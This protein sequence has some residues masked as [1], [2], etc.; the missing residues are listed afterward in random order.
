MSLIRHTGVMKSRRLK[1]QC[2][3]SRPGY[4]DDDSGSVHGSESARDDSEHLTGAHSKSKSGKE[5][6]VIVNHED[7]YDRFKKVTKKLGKQGKRL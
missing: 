4:L 6:I 2:G 3:V 1:Q 7:L 5:H